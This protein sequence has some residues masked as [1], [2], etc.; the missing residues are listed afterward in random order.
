MCRHLLVL[1]VDIAQFAVPSVNL[2]SFILYMFSSL[3]LYWITTSLS[4]RKW[5]F[6]DSRVFAYARWRFI[7]DAKHAGSA[8]HWLRNPWSQVGPKP[9]P[10]SSCVAFRPQ[11]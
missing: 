9:L 2:F 8:V 5:S 1:A 7:V 4:F 6:I 3:I 10:P 11:P